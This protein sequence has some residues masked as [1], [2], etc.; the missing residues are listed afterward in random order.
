MG[1]P[2]ETVNDCF[3]SAQ[4]ELFERGEPSL[5]EEESNGKDA[6]ICFESLQRAWLDVM[7][8][9]VHSLMGD[10]AADQLFSADADPQLFVWAS[11][12]EGSSVHVPHIHGDSAIS[13]VFYVAVPPLAGSIVFVDPRGPDSPFTCNRLEHKPLAGEMLLFPPWLVHEVTSSKE[14]KQ[15]RISLSFNLL[16]TREGLADFEQLAASSVLVSGES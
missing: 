9:F 10:E 12:H 4:R 14:A 15:A 7:W 3:F 8:E 5:W 11:V 6:L 1:R 16:T 2:G 13:G